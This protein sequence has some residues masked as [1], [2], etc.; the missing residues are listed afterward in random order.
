MAFGI[1]PVKPRQAS[2]DERARRQ[3]PLE[4]FVRRIVHDA[5]DPRGPEVALERDHDL[6]GGLVIGS[7]RG[8]IIAE[9]AEL[10]LQPADDLTVVAGVELRALA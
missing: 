1:G 4:G 5:V 7:G 6:L 2:R 3:Q 8:E 10:A 9:L